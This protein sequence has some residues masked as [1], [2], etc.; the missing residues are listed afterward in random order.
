MVGLSTRANLGEKSLI[1][2]A[3]KVSR[4]V[5]QLEVKVLPL[6]ILNSI[7]KGPISVCKFLK[8]H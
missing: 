6:L 3:L 2:G 8:V 1:K 7:H 5:E 4:T